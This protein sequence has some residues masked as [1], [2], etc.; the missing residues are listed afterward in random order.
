MVDLPRNNPEYGDQE[1][2]VG[3]A[4]AD[5]I[6]ALFG[7]GTTPGTGGPLRVTDNELTYWTAVSDDAD[8]PGDDYV[9]N[10]IIRETIGVDGT[11]TWFNVTQ[12]TAI[13]T[14]PPQADLS[15][16]G[17][18]MSGNPLEDGRVAVILP[19]DKI[20]AINPPVDTANYANNDI[21]FAPLEL[22]SALFAAGR[23]I[24]LQDVVTA[25]IGTN[26]ISMDLVFFNEAPTGTYTINTAIALDNA[27]VP[28]VIGVIRHDNTNKNFGSNSAG[29][30]LNIN[31]I[32][33]PLAGTSVWVMG[34]VRKGGVSYAA[35][36]DL[37]IKLGFEVN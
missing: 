36:T 16:G 13:P 4:V 34:I 25:E 7:D 33:A 6:Q 23:S 8:G 27:D 20:I 26:Q 31:L 28:R 10:D 21:L 35:A 17:G 30:T 14:A 19:T 5:A 37:H 12:R 2:R 22:T 29:R 18:S 32:L 11:S 3:Y 9:A 15:F 1:Q 24:T